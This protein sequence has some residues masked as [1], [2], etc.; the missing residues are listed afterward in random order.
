MK[1]KSMFVILF[2][3][4]LVASIVSNP[5]TTTNGVL[6]RAQS[7]KEP[8]RKSQPKAVRYACPMHPEVTAT[9][10]GRRCPKCG[11]ALRVIED[12]VDGTQPPTNN[13]P[14][15]ET[16]PAS[17]SSTRI[18]D[19]RIYDQSGT[20]INFY[21]DLVKGRTVAINFIFTTC[22]TICP[23]LTATF[24]RVQRELK[25][26]AVEAQLISVSVDPA[27]DTPE[28]L[29]DFAAKFG[30]ESGWTFVTGD[31]REIDSLLK[32][33]GVAVTDKNDHTPMILIGNDAANFWTRAYGLSS[34]AS[35]T[36]SITEAAARR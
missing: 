25:A 9:K 20:R 32:A 31:K 1:N 27:T 3:L 36:K 18:P 23:P 26:S 5:E 21:A 35:L 14:V 10:P 6:V 30:A 15:V 11:M 24:R 7:S 19:V 22:T 33:F 13:L 28:R 34:P 2:V 8:R 16:G 4:A 12:K 29:R 17:F